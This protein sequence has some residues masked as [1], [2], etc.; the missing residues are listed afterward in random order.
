MTAPFSPK[1]ASFLHVPAAS[2]QAPLPAC[3]PQSA[4]G[5]WTVCARAAAPIYLA[6]F[7]SAGSGWTALRGAATSDPAAISVALTIGHRYELAGWVRTEAL[8]VRDLDLSPIATG[9]AIAMRQGYPP[10]RLVRRALL[11]HDSPVL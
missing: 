2:A 7:D 5:P 4:G 3:Y 8:A 10:I 1:L 6:S 11:G 9:A